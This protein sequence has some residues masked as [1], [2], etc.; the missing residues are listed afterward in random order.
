MLLTLTIA[1]VR[2]RSI[3]QCANARAQLQRAGDVDGEEARR[4]RRLR[5]N[6]RQNGK[7]SGIV[8]EN[9]DRAE[10]IDRRCD[11]PLAVKRLG[12]VGFDS[13]N[14]RSAR[15]LDRRRR[16]GQRGL[17]SAREGDHAPWRAK[18]RAIP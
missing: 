13:Q 15:L 4:L 7:M 17:G 11:H 18:A 12:D 6:Q 10:A 5:F 2:P 1:P 9:V 3:A 8:D 14:R 16:F